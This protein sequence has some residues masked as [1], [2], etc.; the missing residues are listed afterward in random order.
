MKSWIDW[1]EES[2]KRVVKTSL[3]VDDDEIVGLD[4]EHEWYH[5]M[6]EMCKIINSW[7][8]NCA[9]RYNREAIECS[10]K[11]IQQKYSSFAERDYY[12]SIYNI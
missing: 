7:G 2:L 4:M 8:I 12:D 1:D 6:K 9:I 10:L 3:Y 11:P 5:D